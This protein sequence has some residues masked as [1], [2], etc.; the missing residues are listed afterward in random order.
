MHDDARLARGLRGE[1]VMP[2]VRGMSFVDPGLLPPSG[3]ASDAARLAA[4]C[5]QL[6]LDFCFVP[7]RQ[8]WADEAARLLADAGAIPFFAVDGV[9]SRC[10][11]RLGFETF[12]RRSVTDPSG[13]A[14]ELRA[15]VADLAEDVDRALR[16]GAQAIVVADDIAGATGPLFDPALVAQSIFSPIAAII[17]S[18]R[19]RGVASVMHCDGDARAYY[20]SAAEAGFRAVHGDCG[21]AE[22]VCASFQAARAAGLAF[23]GGIPTSALTDLGT[24]ALAGA[25]AGTMACAGGV[26]VSDDGGA[27]TASEVA[28]LIAALAAASGE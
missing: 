21:G 27:A 18:V 14:A 16:S 4:V 17:G 25:M 3:A 19:D 24:A 5:S 23:I 9:A 1:A 7:A 12:A 8:P 10:I 6:H 11:A 2:V 28:A 20:R 13:V 26:L 15:A 22:N